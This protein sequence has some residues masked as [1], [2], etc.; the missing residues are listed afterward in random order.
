MIRSV[1]VDIVEI[2]RI[3]RAMRRPRFVERIFTEREREFVGTAVAA[4][5]AAPWRPKTMVIRGM[6]STLVRRLAE[7]TL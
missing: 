5:G 6:A 2:G 1:G 4:A 3:E 7:A